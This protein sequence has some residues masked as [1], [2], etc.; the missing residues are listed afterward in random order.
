MTI[1]PISGRDI[2]AITHKGHEKIQQEGSWFASQGERPR[3]KPN[4]PTPQ[5]YNSSLQNCE[6]INSVS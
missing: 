1:F 5:S 3:E 4:L 2:K 6:K